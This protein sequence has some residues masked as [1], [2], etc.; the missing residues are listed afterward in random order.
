[1]E[2][3]PRSSCGR[4][5][6]AG[7]NWGSPVP[8]CRHWENWV[9]SG[10]WA[11]SGAGERGVGD[12]GKS[13][14]VRPGVLVLQRGFSTQEGCPRGWRL[15]GGTRGCSS[16]LHP[17]PRT[18]PARDPGVPGFAGQP[19]RQHPRGA[20]PL[21]ISIPKEHPWVL[22]P[23]AFPS[24]NPPAAPVG[25]QLLQHLHHKPTSGST[26]GCSSPP[27]LHLQTHLKLQPGML[28]PPH[29][30]L[31]T[32]P[33][34]HPGVLSPS[35]IFTSDPPQAAPTGAHPLHVSIPKPTS[36][37]THG[38]SATLHLHSKTHPKEHPWVLNPSTSPSPNPPLTAPM[39]AQPLHTDGG[40]V[41]AHRQ[42]HPPPA[43]QDPPQNLPRC[44]C[45]PRSVTQ[46]PL[47]HPDPPN[48]GGSG[49]R[50]A[51]SGGPRT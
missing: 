44:R 39:G 20:Q 3:P 38:C 51:R 15:G 36:K 6:H 48:P 43:A 41:G 24:L 40:L 32:H 33:K 13:H 29:L 45:H 16:P 30:H 21:H 37:S 27:R 42:L 22:S 18:H 50:G 26:H 14:P 31:Q 2:H 49:L 25:A 7:V 12:G 5:D 46:H 11:L 10:G 47:T 28:T 23:S 4:G 34:E 8:G 19:P 17:H 1:M 9:R 35:S